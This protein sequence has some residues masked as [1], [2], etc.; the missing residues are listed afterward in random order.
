MGMELP[1]VSSI[2]IIILI[3]VNFLQINLFCKRFLILFLFAK[4]KVKKIKQKLFFL[5]LP[6]FLQMNEFLQTSKYYIKKHKQL[7]FSN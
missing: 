2:I 7:I 4:S 1:F 3:N 6:T 5:C